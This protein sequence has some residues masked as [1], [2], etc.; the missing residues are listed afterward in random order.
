MGAEVT[1]IERDRPAA[2]ASGRNFGWLHAS[3]P[4]KPYSFHHLLRLSLLAY[5]KLETE[6]VLIFIGVVLS[7]GMHQERVKKCLQKK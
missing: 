5:Q 4:T 1:V 2:H 6:I 7:N 3:Y